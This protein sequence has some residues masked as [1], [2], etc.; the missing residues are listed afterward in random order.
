MNNK[1]LR[2]N[3]EGYDDPTACKAIEH[4]DREYNRYRKVI[5][6]ILRICELS[7]YAVEGRVV[8]KDKRTGKIWR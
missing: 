4:A 6:C 8:L 3:S 5:G 2:K 1:N 7:G